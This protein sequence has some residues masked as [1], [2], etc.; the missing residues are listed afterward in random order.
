MKE[1]IRSVSRYRKK[2]I[3]RFGSIEEDLPLTGSA[4]K[5]AFDDPL[6]HRP[7]ALTLCRIWTRGR[8]DGASL[9][10][11]TGCASRSQACCNSVVG[12][13]E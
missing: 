5:E 10:H 2:D 12:D 13:K 4:K 7:T 9:E 1:V 8:L 11:S 6:H 3:R